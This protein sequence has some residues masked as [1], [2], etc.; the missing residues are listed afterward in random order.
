[1]TKYV[2]YEFSD[3]MKAHTFHAEARQY[4]RAR[5]EYSTAGVWFVYVSTRFDKLVEKRTAQAVIQR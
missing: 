4:G 3:D 5:M 2:A 1:M